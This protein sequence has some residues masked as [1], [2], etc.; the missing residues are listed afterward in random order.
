MEPVPTPVECQCAVEG[1]LNV[2][3]RETLRVYLFKSHMG[4]VEVA[5][6]S[7]LGPIVLGGHCPQH[8][9][10]GAYNSHIKKHGSTLYY[11]SEGRRG[12][13]MWWEDGSDLIIKKKP[14]SLKDP[15]R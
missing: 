11:A 10:H 14:A 15:G 13:G 2:E 5:S 9:R 4:S 12:W 8:R 3:L 6:P 7:T 1:L